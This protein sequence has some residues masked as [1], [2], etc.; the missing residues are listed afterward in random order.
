MLDAE[1]L[2]QIIEL[3]E[4]LQKDS[5]EAKPAFVKDKALNVLFPNKNARDSYLEQ[6]KALNKQ[7]KAFSPDQKAAKEAEAQD[8][9]DI[10]ELFLKAIPDCIV[11]ETELNGEVSCIKTIS[12]KFQGIASLTFES[13]AER[14]LNVTEEQE[15]EII[16]N[17][18]GS[19]QDVTKYLKLNEEAYL[20]KDAKKCAEQ[21]QNGCESPSHLDGVEVVTNVRLK[22][23]K[24]G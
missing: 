22:T 10:A 23:F 20:Q 16:H 21:I 1:T 14:K 5:K 7:I 17:L 18:L 15:Q 24:A 4:K 13:S 8:R 9:L 11:S 12:Q 3:C 6:E 19:G 2:L